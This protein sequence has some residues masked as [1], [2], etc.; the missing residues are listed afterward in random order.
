VQSDDALR[1]DVA[2]Q[3]LEIGN[4]QN[5]LQDLALVHDAQMLLPARLLHEASIFSSETSEQDYGSPAL[6]L[7]NK[8]PV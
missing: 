2:W 5:V 3:L 6:G 8:K 7:L 4:R 1:D